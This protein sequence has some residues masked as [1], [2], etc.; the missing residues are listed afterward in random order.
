ML[1]NIANYSFAQ[2]NIKNSDCK[3]AI[4]ITDSVYEA[5]NISPSGYGDIL[6][7]SGNDLYNPMF[8][9]REHNSAWYK[10][11][12]KQ[13][14]YLTLDIVPVD[15]KNDYDFLLFRNTE[16]VCNKIIKKQ[17]K[18]VR[19][20]ISRND[21]R[22]AGK[23]GLSSS[24]KA[25]FVHAGPGNSYSRG[26]DIKKGEVYYLVL[27]NVYPNGSGHTVYLHF[28]NKTV[29]VK[30]QV[31]EKK[32]KIDKALVK[33]YVKDDK[34][35]QPVY[36]DFDIVRKKDSKSVFKANNKTSI[37]FDAEFASGY[38]IN[39]T[40]KNYLNQTKEILTDREKSEYI[41]TLKLSS[42]EIGKSI[43]LENIYFVGNKAIFLPSSESSLLTL[44][45]FMNQN[46]SVKI[47]IQGHV[48]WPQDHMMSS[49]DEVFNQ[50]LSVNR[51]K[52]VYDFLIN[53]GID[54][55]RLTYKGYSNTRMIYPVPMN[56]TQEQKN[57]RVEILIISK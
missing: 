33:L 42:I 55:S 17:T 31:V 3:N 35:G 12:A 27:D 49:D 43:S 56:E 26:L 10:F 45:K 54:K 37:E 20:N 47:E 24:A 11:T 19:S 34:S 53:K 22:I 29:P 36:A 51:A 7:F 57:R 32:K 28:K 48:N 50:R 18:P 21:L 39:C 23:T 14:S 9:Q 25:D 13:D 2:N 52:A 46:S 5:R 15:S 44:Y 6:E 41:D 40:A 8:F 38:I 1:I 30:S 4:E 16:G